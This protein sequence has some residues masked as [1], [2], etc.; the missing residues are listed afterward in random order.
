LLSSFRRSELRALRGCGFPVGVLFARSARLFRRIARAVEAWSIHVPL[1]HVNR[2]LVTR[3][4]GDGR[5]VLVFTVNDRARMK[6]M[7]DI[8]VDGIFTDFPDRWRGM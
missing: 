4:H 5:R 8:G 7:E 6:Q 2:G 3:A 1:G